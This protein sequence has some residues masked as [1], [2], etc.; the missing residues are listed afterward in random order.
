[1]GYTWHV[2]YTTGNIDRYHASI[3]SNGIHTNKTWYNNHKILSIYIAQNLVRRDYSKGTRAHTH[4]HT[5][6]RAHARTHARTHTHTPKTTTTTTKH[7]QPLQTFKPHV[8]HAGSHRAVVGVEDGDVHVNGIL[9]HKP[10]VFGDP[11]LSVRC[12]QAMSVS[13]LLLS[14]RAPTSS[15]S[16]LFI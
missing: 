9:T 16:S 14:E 8:H 6:T 1:M 2:I 5:H 15:S 3:R 10:E 7:T 11:D 13:R 4:T 12:K